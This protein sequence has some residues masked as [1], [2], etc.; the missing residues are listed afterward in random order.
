VIV[1]RYYIDE[2]DEGYEY[3]CH[4]AIIDSAT[5]EIILKKRY[6]INLVRYCYALNKDYT[7]YYKAVMEYCR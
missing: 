1:T 7:I 2:I 4:Y 3:G 6:K 5:G